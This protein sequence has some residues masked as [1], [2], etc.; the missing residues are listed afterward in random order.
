M[1]PDVFAAF[2]DL[3]YLAL[4]HNPGEDVANTPMTCSEIMSMSLQD[5]MFLPEM[6]QDTI[7]RAVPS[8]KAVMQL[9]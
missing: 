6:G 1:N 3:Q 5:S 9:A 2:T 4:D 7:N 8:D